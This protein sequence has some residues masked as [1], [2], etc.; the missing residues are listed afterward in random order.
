MRDRDASWLATLSG[1]IAEAR[2]RVTTAPWEERLV[3]KL[4]PQG[5]EMIPWGY[6]QTAA[7]S[8]LR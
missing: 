5:P 8:F 7:E 3:R 6:C 2:E 1:A 4:R